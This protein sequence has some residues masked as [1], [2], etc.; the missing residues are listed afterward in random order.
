VF[1]TAIKRK[2]SVGA[3][4]SAP[5]ISYPMPLKMARLVCESC[6]QCLQP[7]NQI[8]QNIGRNFARRQ[9]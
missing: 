3:L 2:S 9:F 7:V 8:E 5:R 6:P 4:R 1:R